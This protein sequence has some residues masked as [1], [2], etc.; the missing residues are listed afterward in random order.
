[1]YFVL[2]VSRLYGMHWLVTIQQYLREF[3]GVLY[4]I[5]QLTYLA[6]LT[7][8]LTPAPVILHIH[9]T[10][11]TTDTAKQEVERLLQSLVVPKD[12]MIEVLY[13]DQLH[14]YSSQ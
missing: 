12:T 2:W 13:H 9:S 8:L 7:L 3:Q 6:Y 1:M 4:D 14:I 5:V 10:T 11:Y